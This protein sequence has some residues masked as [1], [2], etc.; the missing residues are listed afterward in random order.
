VKGWFTYATNLMQALP[1]EAETIRAIQNLDLLVVV[2]VIPSE[3]AGWADV[4]LPESVY[5]ER[6]DDLNVEWFREPFVALR[7]PVVDA[8]NDQK[9]NWWM[10]RELARKLGLEA[11]YPWKTIEDYLDHRL[12]A[13]GLSFAELQKTG[14][15]HGKP[16]PVFFD[17]GL[18]PT[19]PTP[20][21]K[22]EFYS[23]QLQEKGFDPVPKYTPPAPP[24][25]GSFRLLFGRAPVHSFGRTQNNPVL[26]EAMEENEVWVNAAVA[27]R[28][29]LA[30]GQYV[31]L[32]NQ[33]G[34]VSNRVRLRATERI[35]PDCVY[36]V[37]G[38]GHTATRLRRAYG[39]G[40]SDTQMITRYVTDPLM[41]G[42]GMQVN[43]VSLEAEV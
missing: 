9:P 32:R 10:A 29:G 20:S 8:P 4:V 37:H 42:T 19:F 36:L 40:A 31:R 11:Y 35:R 33:D 22:I 5:L 30:S 14:I 16:Q 39:R 17:Q 15:V 27:R 13:A 3:M 24:P 7:Q 26:H 1:N 21:G 41:G 43:F 23:T 18:A 34:V 28:A 38:F 2:D 25:P 12:S 6:Y